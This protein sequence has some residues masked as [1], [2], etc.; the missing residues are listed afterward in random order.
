MQGIVKNKNE[1]GFGFIV[2]NDGSKDLFFHANDLK[3][4]SFD[5]LQVNDVVEY[6][7][8]ESD[9]GPKAQHVRVAG[10]DVSDDYDSDE[11]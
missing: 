10:T 1:K 5:E 6:E 3:G 4:L 11:E 9:K 7:I 2:P 8:G